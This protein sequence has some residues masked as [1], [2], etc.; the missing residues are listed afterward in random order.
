ME[1]RAGPCRAIP[2]APIAPCARGI[3]PRRARKQR[4]AEPNPR[5]GSR[6]VRPRRCRNS[7]RRGGA[8]ASAAGSAGE[9][10]VGRR[11][12][13]AHAVVA[14]LAERDRA[15]RRHLRGDR[16]DLLYRPAGR[17]IAGRDGA[18]VSYRDPDHDHVRRGHGRRRGVGDR[19]RARRR[20]CRPRLDAGRACAADRPLLRADLHAG[21]ADLRPRA[22][23]IARRPRQCADAGGR[24]YAD[25]L[26]R[27]GHPVADEHHGRHFARHRQHEAAVADDALVRRLP[28]HSRRHARAWAWAR[29]RNSACAASPPV[30]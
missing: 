21:H 14:G 3:I 16:R 20:R 7:R 30:R 10:R 15:H 23:G 4:A 22:A 28:D 27:R 2:Q 19:P 24:L 18:G 5:A 26:R 11:P 8:P 25:I 1:G 12:D 13:P 6:N 9:E 29:S 17:G